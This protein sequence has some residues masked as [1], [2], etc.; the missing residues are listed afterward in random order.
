MGGGR[1]GCSLRDDATSDSRRAPP[2]NLRAD[3][4]LPSIDLR[5]KDS[6]VFWMPSTDPLSRLTSGFFPSDH[7]LV[8]VD[9]AVPGAAGRR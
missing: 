1:G 5:I 2:G 7:R 9:V 6:A 8:H 4:V 3:Y